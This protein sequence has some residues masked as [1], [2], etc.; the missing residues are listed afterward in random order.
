[1]EEKIRVCR[2]QGVHWR[3]SLE[4]NYFE[5]ETGKKYGVP[6]QRWF[7]LGFFGFMMAQQQFT[8]S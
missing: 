5:E 7:N 6:T 8:F 1:M 3:S 4:S 2:V